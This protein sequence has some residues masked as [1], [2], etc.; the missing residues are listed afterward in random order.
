MTIAERA[1]P[2]G[3]YE[4]DALAWAEQQ[5]E[6]LRRLAAG[7]RVNAA[8]DWPHVIEEVHDLGLSELRACQSLLQQAIMHLLKLHAWPGDLAAGHW[9]EEAGISLDDAGRRFAPSMRQRI[10]LDELYARAV[11]RA[12]ANATSPAGSVAFPEICPFDL[13]D[14]SSRDL[15]GL[16]PKLAA[17]PVA[18]T[19]APPG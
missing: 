11:R 12:R 6:L 18:G 17:Q 2:D 4:R 19:A 13:D 8:V 7:E 14:L 1:T 3:L 9:R 10:G 5:A 15:Q 16:L